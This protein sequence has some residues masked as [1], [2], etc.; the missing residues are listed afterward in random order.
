MKTPI[1]DSDDATQAA[2]DRE[3]AHIR[4]R[5]AAL[6]R[7]LMDVE[8]TGDQRRRVAHILRQLTRG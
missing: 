2:L 5:L 4:R 1:M 7:V 6:G 8:L 3:R